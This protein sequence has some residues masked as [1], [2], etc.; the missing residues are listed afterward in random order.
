M[1]KMKKKAWNT[2]MCQNDEIEPKW[3]IITKITNFNKNE[4]I[5]QRY[6]NDM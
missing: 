5:A 3:T 2:M 1:I 4:E 6:Q